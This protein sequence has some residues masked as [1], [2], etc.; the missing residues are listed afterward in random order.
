MVEEIL[1]GAWFCENNYPLFVGS[2]SVIHLSKHP[3]FHSKFKHIGVR[4]HWIHDA[5]DAKL[6]K[7]Y[8]DDNG[9]DMMTK[10]SSRNKFEACCNITELIVTSK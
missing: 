9:Y 1:I 10:A 7:V 6:Y 2:Q 3:T 4:Y 8:I 5:L